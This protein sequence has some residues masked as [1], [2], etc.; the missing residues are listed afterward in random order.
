MRYRIEQSRARQGFARV[1]LPGRIIA[2]EAGEHDGPIWQ[3][4][5]IDLDKE[6]GGSVTVRADSAN[7]AVWRVARA[8]VRAVSQLTGS[9][10]EGELSAEPDSFLSNL[11]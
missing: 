7:D 4:S 10:I 6:G 5:L 9:P 2:V 1:H 8:A 11:S 3:V